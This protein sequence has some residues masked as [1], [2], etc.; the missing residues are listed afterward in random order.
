MTKSRTSHRQ[1]KRSEIIIAIIGLVGILA[2]GF[3]SNWDKIFPKDNIL[4]ATY[5]YRPTGNFETEF[6]YYLEI[7]GARAMI[8]SMQQQFVQKA[9]ENLLSQNPSDT[10]RINRLFDVATKESPRFEDILRDLLPIYQKYFSLGEIQELNR[11]Y[12]TDVMQSFVKKLPLLTQDAAPI[13]VKLMQDYYKR[14]D[15]RLNVELGP[16]PN[17]IIQGDLASPSPSRKPN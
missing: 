14:L 2:T 17:T 15:D 3:L 6:R 5:S 12:S 10:E 16:P 11:F 4:R 8:E 13:Q 7:S 9:K 1:P